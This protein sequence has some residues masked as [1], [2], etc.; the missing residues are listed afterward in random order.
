M[1]YRNVGGSGLKV[2]EDCAR[3]LD[4]STERRGSGHCHGYRA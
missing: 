4:D 3:Q 1:Q 2:S